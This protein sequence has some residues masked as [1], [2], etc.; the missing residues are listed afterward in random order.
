M[1]S[2][3]TKTMAF[4]FRMASPVNDNPLTGSDIAAFM[5]EFYSRCK[6][7]AGG[8]ETAFVSGD[9]FVKRRAGGFIN[10]LARG[11]GV[12]PRHR[13]RDA[14][15]EACRGDEIRN[16]SF[17]FRIVEDRGMGFVAMQ[18]TGFVR[19]TRGHEIGRDVD[20][21]WSGN[22]RG[23][24]HGL[25]NLVPRQRLVRRD[26]E[27][28]AGGLLMTEQSDERF[29][30]I[31][32]V[33]HRPERQAVAG[34]DERL[35]LA[36]SRDGGERLRPCVQCDRHDGI[37]VRPRRADYG[38]GKC[39]LAQRAHEAIFAG[40]F[41]AR[42]IP[43]RIGERRGFGD[44]PMG[45]R[46]LI[47]ARA[48]D[49]NILRGASAKESDALFDFRQGERNEIGDGVER[50]I[51]DGGPRGRGVIDVRLDLAD[52]GR[53]FALRASEDADLKSARD[54]KLDARRADAAAAA[55]KEDF[56]AASMR[57][58]RA[59]SKPAIGVAS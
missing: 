50:L 42:I 51:A 43:V 35:A 25:V 32:V 5:R 2:S 48:A 37:A 26:V 53:Q 24:G 41:V 47:R 27:C 55:D 40:D 4:V 30:K 1:I 22:S 39:F 13:S 16:E 34:N 20:E 7:A 31:A 10:L 12:E 3:A 36:Q 18:T 33:R 46:F 54:G 49:E 58:R 29:R 11:V 17:D 44:E 15:T 6:F 14:V 45:K 38:D 57:I 8:F 9:Q 59:K 19:Q 56:H 21:L 28:M 23:F 52:A